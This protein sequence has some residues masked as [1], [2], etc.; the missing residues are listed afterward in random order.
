MQAD[1]HNTHKYV[2]LRSLTLVC[3]ET[4][5]QQQCGCAE[6]PVY[7]V[8]LIISMLA[9]ASVSVNASLTCVHVLAPG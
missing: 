2:A 3:T 4:W 1:R 5:T 7:L 6:P 8:I 9:V